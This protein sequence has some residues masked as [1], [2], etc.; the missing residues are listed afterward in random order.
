MG[1]KVRE[2]QNEL[3]PDFSLKH[4]DLKQAYQLGKSDGI[5][6]F[7][8]GNQHLVTTVHRAFEFRSRMQTLLIECYLVSYRRT[9]WQV[10]R[11]HQFCQTD[12][13]A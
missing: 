6:G 10:M 7:Q 4:P 12:M 3:W 1:R 8:F 11:Y 9:S 5:S 13:T 2:N